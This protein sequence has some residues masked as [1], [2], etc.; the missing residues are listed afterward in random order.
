MISGS[1][2]VKHIL[3]CSFPLIYSAA[4]SQNQRTPGLEGGL[5]S[6]DPGTP[7]PLSKP[8]QEVW[9]PSV[10]RNSHSA[11]LC[12][13][14]PFFMGFSP[15]DLTT[16]AQPR[17]GQTG[18]SQLEQSSHTFQNQSFQ[19]QRWIEKVRKYWR[20][21][22]IKFPHNKIW[23]DFHLATPVKFMFLL[24]YVLFHFVTQ[25]LFTAISEVLQII[26]SFL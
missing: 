17:G 10:T 1:I 9:A 26:P 24:C 20:A 18:C 21:F 2:T 15:W 3:W 5:Q 25:S 4:E 7:S 6:S 22:C 13:P 11:T 12:G 8:H 14:F 16:V 23:P 19:T